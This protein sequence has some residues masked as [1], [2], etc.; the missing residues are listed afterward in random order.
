[1]MDKKVRTVF[2]VLLII[3]LVLFAS[4]LEYQQVQEDIQ[5]QADSRVPDTEY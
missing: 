4:H 1:M 2:Y 3:A 5:A